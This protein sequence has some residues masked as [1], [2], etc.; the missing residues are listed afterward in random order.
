MLG[1]WF[2]VGQV[3]SRFSRVSALPAPMASSSDGCTEGQ[4]SEKKDRFCKRQKR[5]SLISFIELQ[6]NVRAS[7]T[8]VRVAH[9]RPTALDMSLLGAPP[10]NPWLIIDI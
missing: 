7:S 9:T 5:H 10:P 4:Q 8:G 1:S 6:A 2:S 3:V